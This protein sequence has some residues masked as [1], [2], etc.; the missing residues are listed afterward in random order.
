MGVDGDAIAGSPVRLCC[1]HFALRGC[2]HRRRRRRVLQ[3]GSGGSSLLRRRHVEY[4]T[5]G[6]A[7]NCWWRVSPEWT[8]TTTVMNEHAKQG[9]KVRS[10]FNVSQQ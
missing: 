8:D 1:C 3:S 9:G 6:W 4:R 10:L 7:P 2:C 5:D